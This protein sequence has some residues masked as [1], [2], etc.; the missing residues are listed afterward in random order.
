[1]SKSGGIPAIQLPMGG[2]LLGFANLEMRST[3]CTAVTNLHT[4]VAPLIAAMSCQ[5][6]VLKLLKPLIDVI[7]GLPNPP[8]RALQEFSKAAL[9]LAPCLLVTT[10]SAVLPF[11]HDLL[12]LEIASLHCFLRDLQAVITLASADPSAVSSSDVRS[13]LD[14]YQP[15]VGTLNLAGELFQLAGFTIPVAPELGEGIDPDSLTADQDAVVT[16]VAVLQTVADTL[17]GCG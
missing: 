6:K 16:F 7:Q 15:I 8:A 9:D 17:G 12:C 4:Q 11:V 2:Q 10:P 13:V 1:M 14:S 5:L 3:D